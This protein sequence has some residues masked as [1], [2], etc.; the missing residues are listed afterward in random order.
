[1][2][3]ASA[4]PILR[5]K[6]TT[7]NVVDFGTIVATTYAVAHETVDSKKRIRRMGRAPRN[8]SPQTPS[9]DGFRKCST[10]PTAAA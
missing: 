5:P 8:P 4:K 10:H 9:A 1:M 7:F 6:K 3:F 2:G